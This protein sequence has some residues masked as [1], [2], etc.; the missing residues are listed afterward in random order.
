MNV[1]GAIKG[2][3]PPKVYI[4]LFIIIFLFYFI[5]FYFILFYFILFYF[6]LFYFIFFH[7]LSFSFIFFHFLSFPFIFII[8]FHFHYSNP[9]PPLSKTKD[10]L[11]MPNKEL[12]NIISLLEKQK[13]LQKCEKILDFEPLNTQLQTFYEK[14]FEKRDIKILYGKKKGERR[15]YERI[16]CR[17]VKEGGVD[18]WRR[19]RM[20]K[21]NELKRK[22]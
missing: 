1:Y 20:M 14:E 2:H 3:S 6:I 21:S 22:G 12:Q 17:V 16:E 7:F 19:W 15:D 4:Y 5:L 9:F 11:F 18:F 13:Y 8:F 10:C